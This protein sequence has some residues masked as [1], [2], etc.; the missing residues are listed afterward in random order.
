MMLSNYPTTL[1][2]IL[3]IAAL[4]GVYFLARYLSP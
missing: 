2:V 1:T 3:S 4:L